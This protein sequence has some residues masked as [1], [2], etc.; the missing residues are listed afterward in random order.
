MQDLV[1]QRD[2]LLLNAADCDLIANLTTDPNK[3]ETFRRLS[4][5]LEQ[6]AAELGEQIVDREG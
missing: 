6:M 5:Q 3:H 1:E 2:K 4:I